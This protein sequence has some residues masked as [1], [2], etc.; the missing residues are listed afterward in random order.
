[1]TKTDKNRLRSLGRELATQPS[2]TRRSQAAA[3]LQRALSEEKKKAANL[4]SIAMLQVASEVF[5][6]LEELSGQD[7]RNVEN[8]QKTGAGVSARSERANSTIEL[9][10]AHLA[11]NEIPLRQPHRRTFVRQLRKMILVG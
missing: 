10:E 6:F 11:A 5:R 1:M 2:A 3:A 4:T 9:S 7:L 8:R